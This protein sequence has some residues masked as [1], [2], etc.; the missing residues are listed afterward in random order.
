MGVKIT[1]R[2][3]FELYCVEQDFNFASSSFL[4]LEC[5]FVIPSSA[6]CPHSGKEYPTINK[7]DLRFSGS[8]FLQ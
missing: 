4:Y 6:Y 1:L 5:Y 3:P 8:S 2:L 7:G